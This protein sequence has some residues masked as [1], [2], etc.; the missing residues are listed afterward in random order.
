M[1]VGE[2]V[3]G[4]GARKSG[5]IKFKIESILVIHGIVIQLLKFMDALGVYERTTLSINCNITT[6]SEYGCPNTRIQTW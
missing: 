5:L 2:V 1:H 3:P 4:R 6:K